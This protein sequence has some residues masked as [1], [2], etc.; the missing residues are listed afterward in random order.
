MIHKLPFILYVLGATAAFAQDSVQTDGE[1]YKAIFE[2]ECIRVLDYS[3]Q[4]GQKTHQHRHPAFFLYALSPFKRT[5]T[6]PDGKVLRREFKQGDT[7]WSEEQ[8]HIGENVGQT[9]THVIIVEMK[10]PSGTG[11]SCSK[12]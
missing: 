8:T 2:N 6:L 11:A 4:P 7:L 5:V 1:K 3:D 9:P 10:R 12:G